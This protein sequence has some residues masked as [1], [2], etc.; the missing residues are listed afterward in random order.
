MKPAWSEVNLRVSFGDVPDPGSVLEMATG[1]RYQVVRVRGRALL[2]WVLPP[3]HDVGDMPVLS[4]R[5]TPRRRK[6]AR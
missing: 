2:C 5:W 1:R 4:W 3:G 6:V